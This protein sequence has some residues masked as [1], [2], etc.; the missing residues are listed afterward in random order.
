VCVC[1]CV[2]VGGTQLSLVSLML[3]TWSGGV[4]FL[5]VGLVVPWLYYA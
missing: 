3:L 1:M 5:L 4:M 2:C